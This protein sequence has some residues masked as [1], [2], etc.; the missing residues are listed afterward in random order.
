MTKN[1]FSG[2]CLSNPL[3]TRVRAHELALGEDVAFHRRQKLLPGSA[4]LQIQATV[5]R[6]QLEEVAMGFPRRRRRTAIADLAEVVDTL[7]RTVGQSALR[8]H[9]F[10]ELAT[11]AR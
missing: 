10:A 1:S 5:Q 11:F 2:E 8:R 6:I 3:R 7:Q 4:G 9:A